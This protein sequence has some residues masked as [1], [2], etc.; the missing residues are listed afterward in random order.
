MRS[1]RSSTDEFLMK[2]YLV[3][4]SIVHMI[5]DIFWHMS[6]KNPTHAEKVIMFIIQIIHIMTI[7]LIIRI[8]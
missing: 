8:M 7:I 2:E 1:S 4:K 3:N 6:F 5:N